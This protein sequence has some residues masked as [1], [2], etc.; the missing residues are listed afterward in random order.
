MNRTNNQPFIRTQRL[1]NSSDSA[2]FP[3]LFTS[4]CGSASLHRST[5]SRVSSGRGGGSAST[6]KG[7]NAAPRA[8]VREEDIGSWGGDRRERAL[9]LLRIPR[10]AAAAARAATAYIPLRRDRGSGGGGTRRRRPLE[11]S[12]LSRGDVTGGMGRR[13]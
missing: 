7:S 3:F 10:T 2:P 6:S 5:C 13:V 1:A 8:G 12:S 4:K 11:D 9:A